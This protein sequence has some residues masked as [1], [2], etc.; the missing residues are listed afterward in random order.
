MRYEWGVDGTGTFEVKDETV[1][2]PLSFCEE[3]PVH[4]RVT[5]DEGGGTPHRV[6]ATPASTS[7]RFLPCES[8]PRQL[9]EPPFR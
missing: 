7:S 2:L 6:T 1:E 8:S 5:D 9:Y 3:L 4:L